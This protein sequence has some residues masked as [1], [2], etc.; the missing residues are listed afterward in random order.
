MRLRP[1][2]LLKLIGSLS[3]KANISTFPLTSCVTVLWQS[4]RVSF[5]DEDLSLP[6]ALLIKD[7]KDCQFCQI[8]SIN[9]S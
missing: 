6:G 2:M 7:K 9:V 5:I 3:W 8:T 4:L 1:I